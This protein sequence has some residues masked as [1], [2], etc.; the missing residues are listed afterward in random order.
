[1]NPKKEAW[2]TLADQMIKNFEKR[3]IECFYC[4][5]SKSAVK[6]AMDIMKDHT[7]VSYGGSETIKEIGLLDAIKNRPSLDLIER[8][9]LLTTEDKKQHFLRCMMSDYFLMSSNAITLDGELVNIDG[10]GNRLACL[11]HG[12]EHVLIFAGMNKITTDADCAIKRIQAV[13][14]P[15]NGVRL[16]TKTPCHIL[17][18]CGDCHSKDCMCC[19]I[20]VTRHSRHTGRIKVIL[21][22][23][24]LGY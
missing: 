12:P 5:D 16:N 8:T 11:I 24:E 10:N 1:M 7:S 9:N 13:A 4:E 3:N 22:S 6:L 14:A 2:K 23:E 20:V 19:Q 15:P 21:I 18:S 17:G